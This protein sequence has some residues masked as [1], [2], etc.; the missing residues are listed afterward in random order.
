MH[1]LVNSCSVFKSPEIGL[2]RL[3]LFMVFSFPL[4]HASVYVLPTSS[5]INTLNFDVPTNNSDDKAEISKLK[6]KK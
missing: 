6:V 4:S 5:S 1:A 3:R 2:L